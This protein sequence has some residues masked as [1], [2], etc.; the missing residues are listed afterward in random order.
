MVALDLLIII[1]GIIYGYSNPGKEDRT[2]ILKKGLKYGLILG[3]ALGLISML[4]GSGGI[5]PLV[6][7]PIAFLMIGLIVS[8]L[9]SI[10]TFIGDFL[11]TKF[12]K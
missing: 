10:G 1:V 11:E 9:F 6:T 2:N 3:A 4:V 8:V 7:T 12:K 5:L